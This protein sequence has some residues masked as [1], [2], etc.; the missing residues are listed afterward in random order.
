MMSLR[1]PARLN[2]A[3]LLLAIAILATSVYW[4]KPLGVLFLDVFGLV[5]HLESGKDLTVRMDWQPAAVALTVS[6]ESADAAELRWELQRLRSENTLLKSELKNLA[7]FRKRLGY[8]LRALS[9]DRI[10]EWSRLDRHLFLVNVGADFGVLAADRVIQGERMVGRVVSVAGRCSLVQGTAS[11]FTQEIVNIEGVEEEY[12]WQGEGRG[13][14]HI[15]VPETVAEK[16]LGGQVFLAE[17]T[18]LA[19]GLVIGRVVGL[20]EEPSG[21]MVHLKAESIPISPEHPLLIL[22]ALD[23]EPLE[24]IEQRDELAKLKSRVAELELTKLRLE[25]MRK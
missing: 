18:S 5:G 7:F 9:C 25:L 2:P 21:G 16:A 11:A 17:S 1:S 22:Q 14:A 4:L 3:S 20:D 13:M 19:G 6:P 8:D 24:A 23:R 15:R 12:V 10:G